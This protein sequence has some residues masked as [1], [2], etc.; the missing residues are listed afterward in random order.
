VAIKQLIRFESQ[1]WP[2]QFGYHFGL[3]HVTFFGAHTALQWSPILAQIACKAAYG[4]QC[5]M[6]PVDEM[7][8]GAFMGMMSAT[9][10]NC[11][12]GIDKERAEQSIIYLSHVMLAYCRQSAQVIGDATQHEPEYIVDYPMMWKLTLFS[13]N[14][15]SSCLSRAVSNAYGSLG[16]EI[17]DWD[18]FTEFV[19][20]EE[21]KRGI[22]YVNNI[23]AP[24]YDFSQ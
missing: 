23:T 16:D 19:D 3:G 5:G 1:F 12:Y 7:M 13:Y 8:V 24:F 17:T 22:D 20:D 14:A 21:C 4:A 9:C 11:Q 18:T 2:G 10:A 15:G 6:Q